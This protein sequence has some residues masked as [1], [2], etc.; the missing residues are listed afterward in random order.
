MKK[1][2]GKDM[3]NGYSMN[4]RCCIRKE[5]TWTWYDPPAGTNAYGVKWLYK[6]EINEVGM[7][8][9][10]ARWD[11]IR[12]LIAVDA[13]RSWMVYQLDVKR[14]LLNGK[15]KE[16]VYVTQPKGFIKK[17]KEA[18]VYRSLEGSHC[19]I[20]HYE[21][22]FKT[23]KCRRNDVEEL[24]DPVTRPDLMYVVSLLSRFM[25]KPKE[26][27]MAVAKRVLRYIKGTINYGL[28]YGKDKS[29]N[30]RVFTDRNYARDLEDRKST[31]GY[32]C[33]F[34]GAAI[35]WSSHKQE[36]V[37][38][39]TTEAE[40][41]AATTCACHC[42][43]LKGLV[44][45]L[46]EKAGTVEVMCDNSSTI[47]LSKN[48]VM[49]RRTKH[50]D[51]RFHYIRELV[52]KDVVQLKFCRSEEQL[53]DLMTKPL[54]LSVFEFIRGKIRVQEDDLPSE[55]YKDLL[56][57]M[58]QK[59]KRLKKY[60]DY[61]QKKLIDVLAMDKSMLE[62]ELSATKSK[63]KLYNSFGINA[64]LRCYDVNGYVCNVNCFVVNG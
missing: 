47:K 58:F 30:L 31:S 10:S 63:L 7:V 39:S 59:Q 48:P 2:G 50:I 17:G 33:L 32:I 37:T 41:V 38:L 43:W 23:F 40:Y 9:K 29:Q 62:K 27:H 18:K 22:R 13:Q 26:E 3:K 60:V 1:H 56:Y 44:E 36:V 14:A 19:V 34:N 24:I 49:H 53:A 57:E 11:T 8:D 55:Y 42:V 5:H 21:G 45:E 52:N 28:Y 51:V 35:C 64:N 25:A 61:E 15:L 20:T 46:E 12:T 16:V 6:H 54:K 4:A